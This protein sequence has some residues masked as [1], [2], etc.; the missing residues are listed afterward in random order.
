MVDACGPIG[1]SKFSG[2]SLF[3]ITMFWAENKLFL[4]LKA[5]RKIIVL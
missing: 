4:R 5:Q 2:H 1:I 3:V